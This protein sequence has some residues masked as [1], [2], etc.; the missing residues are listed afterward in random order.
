MAAGVT[1]RLWLKCT[2]VYHQSTGSIRCTND[3]TGQAIVDAIGYL[4]RGTVENNPNMQ[5]VKA[6]GQFDVGPLPQGVY[7]NGL[8]HPDVNGGPMTMHL[9]PD[10]SDNML[11]RDGFLIHGGMKDGSHRASTG[12]IILETKDRKPIADCKG[13]RLTVAP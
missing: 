8:P 2:C 13:G 6:R 3:L 12:C 10:S 9:I 4:G 1:D 5:G 11:T 7:T